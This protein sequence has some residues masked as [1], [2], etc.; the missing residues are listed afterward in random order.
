MT[1]SQDDPSDPSFD[2]GSMPS[3]SLSISKAV[4]Y[5]RPW[6]LATVGIILVVAVSVITDLPH[7]VS[8]SDDAAAQNGIVKQINSDAA[9][10][11]FALKESY[12]FYRG[13]LA[14]TI[15][16]SNLPTVKN[17]LL[18]DQTACSFASGT[19]F[20]LTQNISPLDTKPGKF[21]DSAYQ[22]T[23]KWITYD[24]VGLINNIRAYFA[25][26]PSAAVTANLVKY[27]NLLE[28]DRNSE[29][30]DMAQASG[31]L[32]TTLTAINIPSMPRLP[33]T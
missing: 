2:P 9:A 20:D 29:I 19:V 4:W 6:F 1:S 30:N 27:Q 7:S 24:A 17:Y 10:C 11:V 18:E 14:H 31:L 13:S 8:K 23:V 32:G 5:R 33:G 3:S 12:S 16:T 26:G 22:M 25:G 15:E 28:S 21:V